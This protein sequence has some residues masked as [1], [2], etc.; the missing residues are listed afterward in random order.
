MV[1]RLCREAGAGL[2][3]NDRADFAMLLEAGE[4]ISAKPIASG[5]APPQSLIVFFTIFSPLAW[6]GAMP[7]VG[8]Q[9][10]RLVRTRNNLCPEWRSVAVSD[11]MSKVKAGAIPPISLRL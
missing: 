8:Y 5:A 4:A 2:V 11:C 9:W 1:A 7:R 3:V 10:H 6:R